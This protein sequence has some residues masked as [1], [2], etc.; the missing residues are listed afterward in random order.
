[1]ADL[2]LTRARLALLRAIGAG[3]V[4]HLR[5]WGRGEKT[6]DVWKTDA[7]PNRTVTKACNELNAARLI[8]TGRATG[9]SIYSPQPW[10]LTDAGAQVLAAHEGAS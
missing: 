9:P 10:E 7:G 2:K 5:G 8:R 4:S 3:H 6:R 1:M